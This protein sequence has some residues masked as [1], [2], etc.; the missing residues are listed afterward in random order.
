MDADEAAERQDDLHIEVTDLRPDGMS[1]HPPRLRSQWQPTRAAVAHHQTLLTVAVTAL[2][3][4]VIVMALPPGAR[5]LRTPTPTHAPATV[6]SNNQSIIGVSSVGTETPTPYPAPTVFV[7]PLGASPVD[8]PL[9][10]IPVA[11]DP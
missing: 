6:L 9:A 11:F 8:C 7:P 4:L 10:S 5:P 2:V 1:T 3:T